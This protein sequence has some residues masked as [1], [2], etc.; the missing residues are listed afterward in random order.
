MFGTSA[1]NG[2]LTIG[3]VI[4]GI[5]KSLNIVNQVIPIYLQAKPMIAKAKD[6]FKILKIANSPSNNNTQPIDSRSLSNN[7]ATISNTNTPTFF[8]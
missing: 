7:N 2:T 5:S 8:H 4:G 1:M 6:A 3:K